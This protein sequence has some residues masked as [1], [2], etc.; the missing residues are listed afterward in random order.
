MVF[1]TPRVSVYV[2]WLLAP[3]SRGTDVPWPLRLRHDW[4]STLGPGPF[5]L[6]V[7]EDGQVGPNSV[8]ADCPGRPVE[9]DREI[10]LAI[11]LSPVC[12]LGSRGRSHWVARKR[13][14]CRRTG[15][16]LASMRKVGQTP[17]GS[18]KE[19]NPFFSDEVCHWD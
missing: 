1:H 9:E 5:H 14:C 15:C 3:H 13:I 2:D 17:V 10:S 6:I 19:V 16:R 11:H 12:Q 7:I 18:S 8:L 4:V